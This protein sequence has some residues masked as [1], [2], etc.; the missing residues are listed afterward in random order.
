MTDIVSTILLILASFR[1]E[2][3]TVTWYN[4]PGPNT[5]CGYRFSPTTMAVAAPI[6]SGFK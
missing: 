2:E 5:S 4:G 3:M 1:P 6:D